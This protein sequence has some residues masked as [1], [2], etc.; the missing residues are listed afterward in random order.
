MKNKQA[1][2]KL[3]IEIIVIIILTAVFL[4]LALILIGF[5]FKEAGIDVKAVF[6]S[7]E[8]QRI[9]LLKSSAD[10]FDLDSNI[11][12]SKVGQKKSVYMLLRNEKPD[13]SRWIVSYTVSNISQD[14]DC[15]SISIDYLKD[16]NLE[17]YQESIL[18]FII[19]TEKNI[20]P[21]TCL[22]LISAKTE[23]DITKTLT[24]VLNLI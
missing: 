16:V 2:A 22:F 21:G 24:L 14:T 18:P 6:Q 10:N 19:K 1:S 23:E 8:Q 4:A 5:I 20:K 11:V 17:P 3:S 12:E 9:E 7:A 15:S 13:K